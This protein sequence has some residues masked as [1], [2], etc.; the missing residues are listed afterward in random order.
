VRVFR[1][2]WD[3]IVGLIM[4]LCSLV[5]Q[6]LFCI[7]LTMGVWGIAIFA[8]G[9]RLGERGQ[10]V[11]TVVVFFA[12]LLILNAVLLYEYFV[13]RRV[14]KL[15]S[16]EIGETV[17]AATAIAGAGSGHI[18]MVLFLLPR[19]IDR[20]IHGRELRSAAT[21]RPSRITISESTNTEAPQ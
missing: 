15:G 1:R 7:V 9:N 8:A 19:G 4:I 12:S 14:R 16:R 5:A 6:L 10:A 18:S 13:R 2:V 11:L 3:M 17:D 20:I 21:A